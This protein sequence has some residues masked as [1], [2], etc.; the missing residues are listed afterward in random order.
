MSETWCGFIPSGGMVLALF[1]RKNKHPK[2]AVQ[3]RVRSGKSSPGND[4][5]NVGVQVL[6]SH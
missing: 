6:G 1:S 5:I 4:D 3:G 2:E